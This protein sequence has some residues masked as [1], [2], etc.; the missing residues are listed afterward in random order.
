[1]SN[2]KSK[3]LLSIGS[4]TKQEAIDYIKQGFIVH[5]YDP[6]IDVFQDYLFVQ[7]QYGNIYPYK[8]AVSDFNG[9]A[10][11]SYHHNGAATISLPGKIHPRSYVVPVVSMASILEQFKHV[12]FLLINCEGTEIPIVLN[13]DLSLFKKCSRI[14]V[15]FH[16][17]VPYLKITKEQIQ[18]CLDKMGKS[19]HY[20]LVKPKHPFYSF[21]NKEETK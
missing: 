3:I 8:L 9:E 4:V 13:T 18:Q 11:L 12:D 2:E 19:F 20:T 17:F 21:I 5:A 1:M 15:S 7:K 6:R 14:D 16:H 10:D